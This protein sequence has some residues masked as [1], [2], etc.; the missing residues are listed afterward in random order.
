MS[1]ERSVRC[2]VCVIQFTVAGRYARKGMR[3][4]GRI[5]AT[6]REI[7]QQQRNRLRRIGRRGDYD[8]L[9]RSL[10]QDPA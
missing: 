5:H 7:I 9:I 8:P 4:H 6:S 1:R 10:D 3:S 2:W